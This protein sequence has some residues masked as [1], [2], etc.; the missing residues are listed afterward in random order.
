MHKV[1]CLADNIWVFRHRRSALDQVAERIISGMRSGVS[2]EGEQ[3]VVGEG[4]EIHFVKLRP[5]T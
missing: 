4:C 1:R 3:L 2:G 5:Y